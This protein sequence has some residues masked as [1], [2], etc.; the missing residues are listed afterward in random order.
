MYERL[1][2]STESHG[3]TVKGDADAKVIETVLSSETQRRAASAGVSSGMS[4]GANNGGSVPGGAG[5]VPRGYTHIPGTPTAAAARVGMPSAGATA[6]KTTT[7]VSYA[8]T[9]GYGGG[10]WR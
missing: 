3:L 9:G 6:T 8:R 2:N 10:Y 4:M 5:M 7:A 1:N